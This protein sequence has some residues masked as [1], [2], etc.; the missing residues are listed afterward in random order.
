MVTATAAV[1]A[2]AACA[3]VTCTQL[4][5]TL[6]RNHVERRARIEAYLVCRIVLGA[7]RCMVVHGCAGQV[8][9]MERL[10]RLLVQNDT[11]QLRTAFL[12]VACCKER[13]KKPVQ[14]LLVQV[15]F[16]PKAGRRR[17]LRK[18]TL[19]RS[20]FCQADMRKT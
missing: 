12:Q 10:A 11:A 14:V 16:G 8:E 5:T 20:S 6:V 3:H 4:K 1:A 18:D 19:I 17:A 13:K 15:H 9:R 2:V 7:L